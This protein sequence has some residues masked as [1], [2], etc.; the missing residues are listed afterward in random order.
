MRRLVDAIIAAM[1]TLTAPAFADGEDLYAILGISRHATQSEVKKAY[2][3][4]ANLYHPDKYPDGDPRQRVA[5][6]KFKQVAIAYETLGDPESRKTYDL[7]GSDAPGTGG[8]QESIFSIFKRSGR[9]LHGWHFIDQF[10]KRY[11]DPDDVLFA[12]LRAPVTRIP[13][14]IV[15]ASAFAE[16]CRDLLNLATTSG[17]GDWTLQTRTI[18]AIFLSPWADSHPEVLNDA[19]ARLSSPSQRFV[20]FD[21]LL[22]KSQ[23]WEE[24]PA[25]QGLWN[26]MLTHPGQHGDYSQLISVTKHLLPPSNAKRLRVRAALQRIDE[27]GLD[28]YMSVFFIEDLFK[29]VSRKDAPPDAR[30]F[31][32]EEL[33]MAVKTRPFR[34]LAESSRMSAG[35]DDAVLDFFAHYGSDL[36]EAHAYSQVFALK[37]NYSL[38]RPDDKV[39]AERRAI[40]ER[41]LGPFEP[42]PLAPTCIQKGLIIAR[43]PRP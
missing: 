8:A 28:D 43:K 41:E 14:G 11:G 12:K 5:E 23:V 34:K 10:E 32:A 19:L 38:D 13:E 20:L 25:F 15:R 21:T 29:S 9:S 36:P 30:R 22:R 1:L 42:Q 6:E 7:L 26:E 24:L 31:Y 27:L 3:E 2:R 17:A 18:Q 40:L 33:K 35:I 16:D 4:K 39:D 37:M